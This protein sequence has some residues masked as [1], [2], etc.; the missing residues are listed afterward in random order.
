[1]VSSKDYEE[2]KSAPG[3]CAWLV[4]G[5]LLPVP[6]HGWSSDVPLCVCVLILSSYKDTSQIEFRTTIM[7][8]LSLNHLFKDPVSKQSHPEA[9]AIRISTLECGGGAQF[10]P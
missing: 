5:C 10:N 1:M 8:S 6:F 3:F 2:K 4:D 9:L 7:T